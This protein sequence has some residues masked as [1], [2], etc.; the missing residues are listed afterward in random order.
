MSSL[1]RISPP[2]LKR[3]RLSTPPPQTYPEPSTSHTITPPPEHSSAKLPTHLTIYSWN[4]NGIQPFLPPQTTK[5]TNILTTPTPSKPPPNQPSLRACLRRWKWPHILALQEVKIAPTDTK[6]QSLIR[7]II[8]TPLDTDDEAASPHHLYDT[9]F[10]LPRDKHNATGFGGKIYGVC[11]L[12]RRDINP[13]ATTT[14]PVPWDIEGR[15]LLSTLPHHKTLIYNI[16][17]ING[18][19]NPY[20]SPTTGQV[21][22]TRHDAKRIF[23]T[24]LASSIHSHEAQGWNVIVAG[25]M[26]ISRTSMDSFPRLR[27][28]EEHVR[29]RA[30]FE[31]KV[32]R[33]C[34]MRDVWRMVRGEERKFTY[35]PRGK[36]WG[37]GGDRVDMV[38][39]SR[40]LEGRVRRVDILDCEE[41][42]GGSDHV[43]LWVEVEVGG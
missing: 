22:G 27:M 9:Y 11:T 33:G 21:I 14:T 43:P 39:V 10:C 25:D 20:R 36:R 35:R 40:G 26:N 17:A 38:L 42:R 16:Y 18:T 19:T 5:I 3:R 7:R 41:E 29:N 12:I 34:G 23:H 8:N 32:I 30:D 6:T 1:E 4:I 2:P 24:H 13:A 31:E 37:E 15:V 28:G